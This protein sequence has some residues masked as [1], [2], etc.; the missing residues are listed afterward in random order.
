MDVVWIIGDDRKLRKLR[1]DDPRLHWGYPHTPEGN[2]RM[3]LR[4]KNRWA[5]VF[6]GSSPAEVAN[7]F[8]RFNL[9][10]IAELE[11]QIAVIRKQMWMPTP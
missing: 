11:R 5:Y 6:V 3:A 2:V 7:R 10:R 4:G 8:N 1:R 9:E